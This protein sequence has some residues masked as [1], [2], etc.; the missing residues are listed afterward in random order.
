MKRE[1]DESTNNIGVTRSLVESR[2]LQETFM[3]RLIHPDIGQGLLCL[4]HLGRYRAL[5]S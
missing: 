1:L 5:R 4:I 3:A 2:I